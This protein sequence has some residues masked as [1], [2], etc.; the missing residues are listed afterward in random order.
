VRGLPNKFTF[1]PLV[2]R[3][4]RPNAAVNAWASVDIFASV[5]SK[6]ADV[7]RQD[8]LEFEVSLPDVRTASPR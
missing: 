8:L 1:A 5:V 7:C 6:A 3:T 4:S 2:A